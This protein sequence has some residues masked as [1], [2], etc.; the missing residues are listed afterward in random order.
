L[1]AVFFNC[2]ALI[3]VLSGCSGDPSSSVTPS[4]TIT[5]TTLANGQVSNSYNQQLAATGGTGI[6]TWSLTTGALPARLQLSASGLLSGTPT[7]PGNS[8]FT[9]QA[10]SGGLTGS[11]SFTLTIIPTAVSIVTTV[12]PDGYVGIPYQ[13]QLTAAGGT[14]SYTWTVTAGTLPAG[15]N[16]SANGMLSGTPATEATHTFTILT[17][18]DAQT[19]TRQLRLRIGAAACAVATQ[20]AAPAEVTTWQW[21]KVATPLGAIDQVWVRVDPEDDNT[22]YA[23]GNS[24]LYVTNDYG[25]TWTRALTGFSSTPVEFVAGNSC[26]VYA[27]TNTLPISR[28]MRSTDRGRTWSTVY[29]TPVGFIISI[30]L[31]RAVPGLILLG[32]S[33]TPPT[34]DRFYRSGDNGITWSTHNVDGGARGLIPWDIEEDINGVLYSG[35]EIYNHPQPY[36]APF[37]RSTDGGRTWQD[38]TGILP[39]HVVSMQSHPSNGTVYAI[40]E[41]AGLYVTTDAAATWNR[42]PSTFPYPSVGIRIDPLNPSRMFGNTV[43]FQNSPGGA[44]ASTN[45]GQ[46][47][48]AVGLTGITVGSMSLSQRSR[49]LFAAGYQSGIWRAIIPIQP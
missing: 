45:A 17:A 2:A 4:L 41:G 49:V 3:S 7:A 40:T 32:V 46:S 10:M 11:K 34:V 28:L 9:V 5:T 39:W 16:L 13:Q 14:G 18:S 31:G 43:F 21:T 30:H 38:V 29:Q 22:W 1:P 15:I 27:Q 23:G 47:F 26:V 25:V 8:A 48:H 35:T 36:R 37:W 33:T 20:P 44:F 12:L 19:A 24:G 42:V 6:Y